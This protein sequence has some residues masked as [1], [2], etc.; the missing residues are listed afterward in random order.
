MNITTSAPR[1]IDIGKRKIASGSGA[2]NRSSLVG[3]EGGAQSRETKWVVFS[4]SD[5]GGFSGQ[6]DQ[7]DQ[8]NGKGVD[9][10]VVTCLSYADYKQEHDLRADEKTVGEQDLF[11]NFL[12]WGI[13]KYPS[14]KFILVCE[15]GVPPHLAADLQQ[16]SFEKKVKF[17]L[18]E[19]D[20]PFSGRLDKLYDLKDSVQVMSATEG[21][22]NA[23]F[24][25]TRFLNWLREEPEVTARELGEWVVDV[26]RQMAPVQ[27]QASFEA[28]GL[29]QVCSRLSDAIEALLE[30][31][32]DP[33]LIYTHMMAA[34]SQ[35]PSDPENTHFDLRDLKD[36]LSHLKADPRLSSPKAAKAL[37]ECLKVLEQSIID[38]YVPRYDELVRRSNGISLPMPWRDSRW[39]E[40]YREGADFFARSGW[41]KLMEY[42]LHGARRSNPPGQGGEHQG[43]FHMGLADTLLNLYKRYASPYLMSGCPQTP[44]CS[45]YT[46]E[47]IELWGLWQ[48][49]KYG[50]MRF[51]TCKGD[52]DH[53][54]DPVPLPPGVE[55][56]VEHR[57]AP[58]LPLF[59][60]PTEQ[61]AEG[62][63]K[64]VHKGLAGAGLVTGN[65]VGGMLAGLTGA[66][67]GLCYGWHV[68]LK[69]GVG[70]L[71]RYHKNL[72]Q[73]YG[74]R[75][76]KALEELEQPLTAVG[77]ML[78]Q[79]LSS[80]RCELE[81]DKP[82]ILRFAAGVCGAI[83]GGLVGLVAGA[84]AAGSRGWLWGGLIGKNLVRDWLDDLPPQPRAEAV[85]K[86]SMTA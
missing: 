77:K 11:R 19:L 15:G 86:S 55:H 81:V 25:Y 51:I 18:A 21:P 43:K 28:E 22:L 69:A 41:D 84:W 71:E 54:H 85:I 44:T 67:A 29:A 26:H 38:R 10:D 12:R 8:A 75:S 34:H 45:Q 62:A 56:G 63:A 59:D 66:V 4:F 37:S 68:G 2:G 60:P 47:A 31:K 39:Q 6:A 72:K 14:A 83:A 57:T 58:L 5:S 9:G 46:R 40:Q 27:M 49:V 53:I 13:S 61:G 3:V 80:D 35:E 7:A 82:P 78:N 73:K 52:L 48:G 16:V 30:D 79:R 1:F 42:V 24:P 70:T 17:A 74:A 20:T 36:F 64:W 33:K 76:V 23:G 50:V 65:L 32:V